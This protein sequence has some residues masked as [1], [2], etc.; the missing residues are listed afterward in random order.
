MREFLVPELSSPEYDGTLFANL[1]V[2]DERHPERIAREPIPP[3]ER[4]IVFGGAKELVLDGPRRKDGG[5]D[6]RYTPTVLG[7]EDSSVHLSSLLEWLEKAESLGDVCER[8]DRAAFPVMVVNWFVAG[9]STV[10]AVLVALPGWGARPLYARGG[11]TGFSRAVQRLIQL[12]SEILDG[13]AVSEI[14]RPDEQGGEIYVP[15]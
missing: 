7:W 5:R 14:K 3:L 2:V 9:E 1:K 15:R 13:S 6:L 10:A 11:F 4:I 12:K 8:G